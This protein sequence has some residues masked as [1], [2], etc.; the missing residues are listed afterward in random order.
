M[1][2]DS[3]DAAA[4]RRG[5]QDAHARIAALEEQLAAARGLESLGR[6]T[7]GIA[8][9]FRNVMAAIGA[10]TELLLDVVP[11][12]ALQ[13]RRVEAIRRASDWGARL[14]HGLLAAGRPPSAPREATDLNA[15][16]SGVVR[17]LAPLLS[18]VDVRTELEPR[19]GA[20]AVG[21]AALEQVAMNLI[22]NAR[23]AMPD[24]G[25][26]T[27]RTAVAPHR[28]GAG[29][30]PRVVFSVEDTGIGMGEATRARAFEPYFTTKAADK[31]MGLGLST[32][33]DIVTWHG[34]HV[35]ISSAP[36]RGATLTVML[37]RAAGAAPGPAV[38]VV[39]EEAGVRD[40]IVEILELHDFRVRPARDPEDAERLGK[41]LATSPALVI[42]DANPLAWDVHRL[43]RLRDAW[44]QARVLYLSNRAS[45]APTTGIAGPTLA[46]PF[47]VDEL[48]S[49][50]REV[51]GR[52]TD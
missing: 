19:V 43:G 4:L 30:E 11:A 15:V 26:V 16:V 29:S 21:A 22:L 32:V 10:Q 23:D 42:A 45:N 44:P 8:H 38:L 50:V 47:S 24:G 25:Q 46:K 49:T 33:H 51:L 2:I 9:D 27:I 35:D 5:L 39:V 34:G 17:T 36:G 18:N 13:R 3:G 41:A 1:T 40:L 12:E 14:A 31:G 52:P 48:V 28:N 7:L 37:P 20:V 6:L